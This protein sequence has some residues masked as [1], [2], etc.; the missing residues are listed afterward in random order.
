MGY[1]GFYRIRN[2][3]K[4][5]GNPTQCV[6]RSLWERK[7][8]KFCDFNK[9]VL[10]WSS[11]EIKV[12]YRSP[13]DN[14]IHRYFVDFWV[15]MVN[16]EGKIQKYLIEIKPKRQTIEPVLKKSKRS[17]VNEMRTFIINTEKWKSA[18]NFCENR[19]WKFLILTEDQ[20]FGKNE[21]RNTR[22]KKKNRK[23]GSI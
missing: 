10:S 11:E 18:R 19:G 8:M 9:N 1:K 12:P 20:L 13:M 5:R 22:N 14:R 21:P 7:F 3:E 17:F 4:Y 15:E 2:P 16:K 6:F 23:G